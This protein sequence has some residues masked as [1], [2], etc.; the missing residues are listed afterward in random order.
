[1]PPEKS[2]GGEIIS[3]ELSVYSAIDLTKI[4][5]N[6]IPSSYFFTKK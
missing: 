3:N 1:M 4:I 5:T 6:Q 2:K